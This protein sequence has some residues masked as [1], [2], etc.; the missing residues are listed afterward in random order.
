[1]SLLF[2]E[3]GT[4]SFAALP[5]P[6]PAHR[7]RIA[8]EMVAVRCAAILREWTVLDPVIEARAD[9][10]QG[11]PASEHRRSSL[12]IDRRLRTIS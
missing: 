9:L 6:G 10:S 3:T 7:Q 11:V 2:I 5:T 12:L 4:G 8:A 1:M